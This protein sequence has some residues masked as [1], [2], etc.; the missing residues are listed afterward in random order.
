[1]RKLKH[2]FGGNRKLTK[3]ALGYQL[4][5]AYNLLEAEV[6]TVTAA[7]LGDTPFRVIMG[8]NYGPADWAIE[9]KTFEGYA[10]IEGTDPNFEKR[11]LQYS[12]HPLE[13]LAPL[14][15]LEGLR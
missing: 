6:R 7:A 15:L 11:I 5:Q 8:S 4:R 12:S 3:R 2:Y 9:V 14:H 10:W 1:V 13:E